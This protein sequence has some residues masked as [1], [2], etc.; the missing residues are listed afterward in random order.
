MARKLEERAAE[1]LFAAG[2]YEEALA[3]YEKA[4]RRDRVG[5]CQERLGRYFEALLDCPADQPERVARLVGCASRR[6]TRWW[7]AGVRARR[8][9]RPRAD[10]AARG[11]AGRGRT[12]GRRPE[13]R[14]ERRPGQRADGAQGGARGAEGGAVAGRRGETEALREAVLAGGRRHFGRLLERAEA[15]AGPDSEAVSAVRADWSRFE[16]E[17]GE[18]AQ[19]ARQAERGGD[20]YRAHRLYRRA[21]AF[22]DADRVLK[23]DDSADGRAARAEARR[24]GGD[25]LGAARLYA[26]AGQPEEAVELFL[27]AEEFGAA[28]DCLLR[29]RGDEAARPR[30]ADCLRR[31][32]RLEELVRLC[33]RAAG[34]ATGSAAGSATGTTAGSAAG[35]GSGTTAGTTAGTTTGSAT[36]SPTGRT[37]GPPKGPPGAE[38]AARPLAQLRELRGDAAL[39][40]DL[41][42]EVDR[43]LEAADAGARRPFGERA[44]AWVARAR[45]ETDRRYAGI[46]GLD[47]GTSTCAVAIY[48]SEIGKPVL[49]P[50]KNRTH[51]PP[52]SAWTGR[53]TNSSASTR[54][55]SSPS[56]WS[57]TSAARSGPW[58]PAPRTG[59]GTAPTARRR[60][61]PG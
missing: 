44:Q 14:P 1:L 38:A 60:W 10:R 55:R 39:P 51:F 16:E 48:D 47:L 36:G 23:G 15:D 41:A 2:Q 56:G 58:A 13:R 61:P 35:S 24:S 54:R 49:C 6:S 25:A 18:T 34:F 43:A 27:R 11:S 37:T 52:R 9:A 3:R 19:A 33:L 45:A 46:W 22:G 30:L 4:G 17:A 12:G 8:P 31:A 26:E 42:A 50:W 40:P 53:A 28:A 7:S 32:G 21:G 57:A 20:A 5:E 29:W 59:S